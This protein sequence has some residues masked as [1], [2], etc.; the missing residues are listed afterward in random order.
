[1][2]RGNQGGAVVHRPDATN[3]AYAMAMVLRTQNVK[4]EHVVS[5]LQ[6]TEPAC[7]ALCASRPDRLEE[8]IPRL[9]AVHQA[10]MSQINN[11][12]AVVALS[13]SFHET[14]VELCGNGALIVIAGSLEAIWSAHETSWSRSSTT[15]EVRLDERRGAL[16]SHQELIDAISDGDA[17]KAREIAAAHLQAVQRYPNTSG[18]S[19]VPAL[20]RDHVATQR[21][22]AGET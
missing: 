22:A 21:E 3:V 8:V 12:P 11:F 13:R 20:I 4:I 16:K 9:N 18:L 17:S 7:A 1:M 10:A 15:D 14:I 2:R 19:V 5:A 6:E